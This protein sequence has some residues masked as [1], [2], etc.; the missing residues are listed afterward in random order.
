LLRKLRYI[1]EVTDSG[2]TFAQKHA[3]PAGFSIKF[4]FAGKKKTA[5]DYSAGNVSRQGKLQSHTIGTIAELY[6]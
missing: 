4:S 6:T 5:N 3:D 1:P 2:T